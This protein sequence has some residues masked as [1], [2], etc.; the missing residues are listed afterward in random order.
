MD[1]KDR[2]IAVLT[3]H[4][5]NALDALAQ[6]QAQLGEAQERIAGLSE[7]KELT[8]ESAKPDSAKKPIAGH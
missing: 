8:P 3:A 1:Q 4:R 5:N 2:L 7:P 6:A